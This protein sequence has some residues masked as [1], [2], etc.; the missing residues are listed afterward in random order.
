MT[1]CLKP[2]TVDEIRTLVG[3]GFVNSFQQEMTTTA[4]LG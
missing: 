3:P 4:K 1:S 2:M